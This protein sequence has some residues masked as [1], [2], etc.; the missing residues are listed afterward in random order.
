MK[1]GVIGAGMVGSSAAYAVVLLGAASEVALV[2]DSKP[3][4][5]SS[6]YRT[7]I[8]SPD[9]SRVASAQPTDRSNARFAVKT[10]GGPPLRSPVRSDL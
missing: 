8:M 3:M 1:V 10:D 6:A 7:I 9:A 5:I 4:M 2:H